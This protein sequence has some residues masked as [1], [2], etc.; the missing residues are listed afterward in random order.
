MAQATFTRTPF[1]KINS[2]NTVR[3]IGDYLKDQ[4]VILG[5]LTKLLARE[6]IALRDRLLESLNE[7][8]EIKSQLMLKLQS[9]D[10]RMRLHPEKALLKTTYAAKV[11]LIKKALMDCKQ[12]NEI[13][14]K[15]IN[16]NINSNRRIS[17]LLM[18]TRDR[19]TR[20]MTY[21]SKGNTTARGLS[22]LSVSC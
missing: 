13:N 2:G 18:A 19:Y 22:R 14:G 21:T 20:N 12:C 5:E 8:S 7:I 11:D 16:F 4:E 1:N 10:Q 3:P 9:N 17:G 6:R 15:L